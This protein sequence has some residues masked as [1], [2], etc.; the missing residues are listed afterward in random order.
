MSFSFRATVDVDTIQQSSA[1]LLSSSKLDDSHN[2]ST[3]NHCCIY[4]C[5]CFYYY[6]YHHLHS[7]G[8]IVLSSVCLRVCVFVRQHDNF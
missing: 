6:R 1:A 5:Y 4:Y 2:G 7:E 3:I 8:C